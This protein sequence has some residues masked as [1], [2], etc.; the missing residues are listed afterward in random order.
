MNITHVVGVR[1]NVF[2]KLRSRD[3]IVVFITTE[4]IF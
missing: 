1:K 2:E 3:E 4:F